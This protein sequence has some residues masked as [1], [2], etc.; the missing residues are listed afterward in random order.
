MTSSLSGAGRLALARPPWSP[1]QTRKHHAD[2]SLGGEVEEAARGPGQGSCA[3]G[4]V[5]DPFACRD[6]EAGSCR[7]RRI[8]AM[9]DAWSC[10]CTPLFDVR[11]RPGDQGIAFGADKLAGSHADKSARNVHGGVRTGVE[12]TPGPGQKDCG[13]Q[14]SRHEDGGRLTP[15]PV[16]AERADNPLPGWD[17]SEMTVHSDG[18]EVP[19]ASDQPTPSCSSSGWPPVLPKHLPKTGSL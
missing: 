10:V 12:I 13:S 9:S 11:H 7:S 17:C 14:G 8:T 5:E 4:N 16:C 1:A 15:A 18:A 19:R 6:H 2:V 3:S